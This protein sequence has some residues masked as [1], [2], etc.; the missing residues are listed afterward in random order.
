MEIISNKV[1]SHS[2]QVLIRNYN[3]NSIKI[4]HNGEII[5]IIFITKTGF[6]KKIVIKGTG[7]ILVNPTSLDIISLFDYDICK[8]F[9]SF[10]HAKIFALANLFER[11]NEINLKCSTKTIVKDLYINKK[12]RANGEM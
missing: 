10:Y 3:F 8:I 4:R 1:V 11:Y 9:Y 5:N 2:N 12:E 7:K 6:Q